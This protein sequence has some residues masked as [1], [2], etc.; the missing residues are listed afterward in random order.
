MRT[1][2]VV[3]QGN[4]P[5]AAV[6]AVARASALALLVLL[7]P[8]PASG[9]PY[10]LRYH[11]VRSFSTL[12]YRPAG[13]DRLLDWDVNSPDGIAWDGNGI[14]VS[15]CDTMTLL[16]LDPN[17]GGE[18][19]RWRLPM[20]DM[21]DHLAWDGRYLWGNIHSMPGDPP[22]YDGRLVQIDV[23]GRKIVHTVEVPFRDAASMTPMGMGWDG[24]Y[25]WTQDPRTD[26]IYRID[27]ETGEGRDAPIFGTPTF[28]GEHV[29]ACGLSWDGYSCL[30][31]SDLA[32]GAYFQVTPDTG[33]MISYLAPPD[34]PDPDRYGSFRPPGVKKLFTG[35]TT[36][37]R[38]VWIVDEIEGNPLLYQIDV[39]FPHAG[40]CAHPVEDGE[41]CVPEGQPFCF[42]GSVCYGGICTS[43]CDVEGQ[44][45]AKDQACGAESGEPVCVPA[46]PDG[47]PCVPGAFPPCRDGAFCAGEAGEAVCAARCNTDDDCTV[48]LLCGAVAEEPVCI[49]EPAGGCSCRYVAHRGTLGWLVVVLVLGFAARFLHPAKR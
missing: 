17:T 8:G 28:N 5:A 43:R 49:Q 3:Q 45:C 48:G 24:R 37:G 19:E 2:G 44:G 40:P 9:E 22:P 26:D 31:I 27:P 41:A 23:E 14:W 13:G 4:T 29:E 15:G 38:R 20:E 36:D 18:I 25:L 12:V 16:K 35:M 33:E 30:W 11:V 34:N 7:F 1:R 10:E 32:H 46:L 21:T 39:D 47:D 42:E 6:R